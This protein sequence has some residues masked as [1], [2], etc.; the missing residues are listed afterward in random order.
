MVQLPRFLER[1]YYGNPVA[2]WLIALAVMAGV[3]VVLVLVRRL[4]IRRL[5]RF[6]ERTASPIDDIVL[7]A[8]QRTSVAF[9]FAVALSAGLHAG[10]ALSPNVE[11]VLD[12]GI[13][14]AFLLQLASWGS[15]G[16]TLWVHRTTN[17]RAKQDK[18]SL[19]TLN[20]L[21]LLARGALWTV[22][23]LLAL[24]AFG[25]DITALVTG[26]GI[27]GVAVALAVQSILGDLFASLSIALDKPFVIGDAIAVDNFNGTV[28]DIG[29]K[30]TRLRALTGETLV[31][32]NADLLK[33]R[34]RNY[35]G[36][37]ERRVTFTLT[38]AAD[39][40]PDRLERVPALVREIVTAEE[41]ARF[42]RSHVASIGSD[43]T[44]G[45]ETV[46]F[47]TTGDYGVYMDMQ[48]R[49]Y[50]ALLR[51]LAV[52]GVALNKPLPPVVLSAERRA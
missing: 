11:A 12:T 47:V 8:L 9:L 16:I 23:L 17:R 46:Y 32:S 29:L 27:A 22:I 3:W 35:R 44:L 10:L 18:A 2:D 13:R 45:V 7:G 30:T 37:M 25:I 24:N 4:A 31:F 26:L 48:Q 40:P 39:T 14:L 1:R 19:A 6:A 41:K 33:S 21:G 36:Q 49:I 38:L 51:R 42:D 15:G 52:E 28:E 50:L 5:E 43:A 20:V 34:I